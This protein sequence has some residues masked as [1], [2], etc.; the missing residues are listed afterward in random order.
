MLG[1]TGGEG[2]LSRPSAAAYMGY[3]HF[4]LQALHETGEVVVHVV[5]HHVD[6]ALHVVDL[7]DCRIDI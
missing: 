1:C 6:A 3:L 4:V 7:V 2:W 5:K